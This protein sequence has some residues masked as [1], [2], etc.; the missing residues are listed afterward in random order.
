M[1]SPRARLPPRLT[2]TIPGTRTRRSA[3]AVRSGGTREPHRRAGALSTGFSRGSPHEARDLRPELLD[4]PVPGAVE[5]DEFRGRDPVGQEPCVGRRCQPV[6]TAVDDEGAGGDERQ[7][8]PAVVTGA[9][10]VVGPPHAGVP[11]GANRAATSGSAP[12][13]PG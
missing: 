2:P 13:T 1:C 8:V 7:E 10:A 11:V 5:H 12:T 9:G 6:V 3:S 4:V